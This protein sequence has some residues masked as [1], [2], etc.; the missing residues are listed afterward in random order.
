MHQS[1]PAS[2]RFVRGA[3]PS[4]GEGG[5]PYPSSGSASS[6]P[7]SKLNPLNRM[8]FNISQSRAEHQTVALPT[9]RSVSTIP[10]GDA[11]REGNWVYPSPQQMYNALMRKGY[12]DTPLDAME[13]MVAVHNF[14]N[15]GAWSEIV[16]WERRYAAGLSHAWQ[17]RRQIDASPGAVRAADDDC[18]PRLLKFEGRPKEMTPKAAIIQMIGKI[19]P[20]KFGCE[21]P[22]DRHDWYVQR[23]A[24]GTPPRE[25]RYVI[26]YYSAPP[27]PTGEPV[28]YLDVR[29]AIDRPA[30]ALERM[31]RWAGP[32]WDKMCGA[33]AR[34]SS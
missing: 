30:A 24:P 14:L 4:T 9:E 25:I 3:A 17:N 31:M 15:E 16:E 19:Y 1:G 18:Q 28:F 32:V 33:S 34:P 5:C 8:P 27:D 26:D 11:D 7:T 22:F 21:P 23:Q 10:K 2:T 29:P 13:E 6:A 12:A 20:R